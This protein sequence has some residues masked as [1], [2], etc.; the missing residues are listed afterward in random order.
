SDSVAY[1]N[2]RRE[3]LSLL[4]RVVAA[5]L[6]AV[7]TAPVSAAPPADIAE[8]F[9]PGTL[10]YA[11]L[12]NPVELAPQLAAVFKGTALE[13][14]IPFI[15]GRKDAAKTLFDLNGKRQLA[16][17]GLLTSPEMLAEFKKLHV[18]GGLTGFT[19]NGD[20]DAA[21]VVLTHDSPAAG[22][23]AR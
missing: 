11:E 9:P 19:E 17:L 8:L 4:T 15:H 14:S 6:L 3:P 2:S 18:A 12:H 20:P 16:L 7:W 21:L 5:T 10:A 1:S 23:A 13:D 22:L